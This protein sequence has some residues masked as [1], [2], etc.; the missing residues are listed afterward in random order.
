MKT[1]LIIALW[2]MLVA[3]TAAAAA[4]SSQQERNWF[5]VFNLGNSNFDV[6][7]WNTPTG[8][9]ENVCE[10]T[11]QNMTAWERRG[12][13]T[14]YGFTSAF[15]G[16]RSSL[17]MIPCSQ[18]KCDPEFNYRLFRAVTYSS[19]PHCCHGYEKASDND[20]GC[21]KEVEKVPVVEALK[22]LGASSFL[23]TLNESGSTSL[24]NMLTNSKQ[25]LTVF[26]LNNSAMGAV[27]NDSR[28][29]LKSKKRFIKSHVVRGL[30]YSEDFSDEETLE[31]LAG[32]TI[33]IRLILDA[34]DP[35]ILANCA[36]L[37]DVIDHVAKNGVIH[38]VNKP[39][40]LPKYDIMGYLRSR[41][42]L[43]VFHEVFGEASILNPSKGTSFTI[44][45]PTNDAF[46]NVSQSLLSEII[47]SPGRLKAVLKQHATDFSICGVMLDNSSPCTL[48]GN[49]L[50]GNRQEDSLTVDDAHVLESDIITTD[51]IIHIIDTVFIPEQ[52]LL[53]PEAFPPSSL[54][55]SV[56]EE[57]DV[58]TILSDKEN[59]TF[60]APN[61]EALQDLLTDPRA[62]DRG[63]MNQVMSAHI[64]Y[65]LYLAH[66][67]VRS[68]GTPYSHFEV[69]QPNDDENM[70]KLRRAVHLMRLQCGRVVRKD[71]E[72]YNGHVHE[73]DKVLLA[74][75]DN[76]WDVINEDSR[77]SIFAKLV[78]RVGLESVLQ[79][80]NVTVFVPTNDVFQSLPDGQL[81]RLLDDDSLLEDTVRFHIARERM[82]LCDIKRLA[83]PPPWYWFYTGHMET[84]LKDINLFVRST[85]NSVM[86]NGITIAE[87]NIVSSNGVI[88]VVNGVFKPPSPLPRFG[89]M[90][91][92]DLGLFGK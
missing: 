58:L 55:A 73:I 29:L 18:E 90:F 74:P 12:I 62:S 91:D 49:R 33:R 80:K 60:L 92:D 82:C 32:G 46:K 70:A 63:W 36:P 61:S 8:S 89:F 56:T 42:D 87:P 64:I 4:P 44:F 53:I 2:G 65:A 52:A 11:Y 59:L 28:N 22:E 45:A 41:E 27:R 40:V 9:R 26:Y 86:V 69:P 6:S 54:I 51:G 71:I 15:S 1:I 48:I 25:L 67:F 3:M 13:I 72:M 19:S 34:G 20:D 57:A 39:I 31:S 30:L 84:Y 50:Q 38:Q 85:R 24:V 76:A 75:E 79:S 7:L 21:S 23:Q 17:S 81:E 66:D 16:A 77:F 83:Y 35:V 88:H 14:F 5:E 43:S 68:D 10:R 78:R 47:A 37:G